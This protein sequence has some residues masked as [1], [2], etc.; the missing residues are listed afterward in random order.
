MEGQARHWANVSMRKATLHPGGKGT[1]S[2]EDAFQ[3]RKQEGF[4]ADNDPYLQLAEMINKSD[5]HI[6]GMP[7]HQAQ[8]GHVRQSLIDSGPLRCYL[9]SAGGLPRTNVRIV[10][11][12][13][14]P[15]TPGIQQFF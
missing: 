6:L 12:R 7:D 10:R 11:R 9:A 4:M 13:R 14:V 2:T 15:R 5:H 1:G 3:S 8:K